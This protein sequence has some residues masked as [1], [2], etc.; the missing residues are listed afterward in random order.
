MRESGSEIS[1]VASDATSLNTLTVRLAGPR[2]SLRDPTVDGG[3]DVGSCEPGEVNAR[4][5]V[6]EALCRLAGVT[7]LRLDVGDREDS[8]TS[9]GLPVPVVLLG[10]GGADTLTTGSAGDDVR[11]GP[12][13][14]RIDTG[15]GEDAVDVRD[16]LAD[17]VSCGDGTDAVEADTADAVAG[18]CERVTRT[19]T[20]PPPGSDPAAPDRTAPRLD[21]GGATVQRLRRSRTIVLTATANEEG[22]IAA[23]G[24]V[25][26]AG[27]RRPVRSREVDLELAGDGVR[28]PVRL[29]RSLARRARR[30]LRRGRRVTA[31]LDVVAT[32]VAG[33]SAASRA[34]RVRLAL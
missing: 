31:R 30:A 10:G 14:D 20:S 11:G 4:G 16:G 32:D 2:I 22:T 8:V 19:Q 24:Y 3:M 7:R 26:I 27:V 9:A 12:G 28:I 21:V 13:E 29:S 17:Q 34:P 33:N 25:E 1:L 6:V 5:L 15:A 23:S 18:D